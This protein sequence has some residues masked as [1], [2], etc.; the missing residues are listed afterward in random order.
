MDPSQ[1]DRSSASHSVIQAWVQIEGNN[2]LLLDQ[3]REQCGSEELQSAFWHFVR[4][5]RPAA[6]LIEDTANGSALIDKLRR[7]KWLKV[8]PIIPDG[9]SKTARLVAHI[10]TIKNG[11]IQLPG[12]ATWRETYITEFLE[13]PRGRNDDQVDATTQYLDWMNTKPNL[14]L[15]PKRGICALGIDRGL[16]GGQ[17]SN[18]LDLQK[19]G[20]VMRHWR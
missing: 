19:I 20:P 16:S 7:K 15:P 12:L 11:R 9:R 1:S 17:F 5:F 13:F 6:C 18:R 10:N 8:V 4:R 3:W 14:A 2:H